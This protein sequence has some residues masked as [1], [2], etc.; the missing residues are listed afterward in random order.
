MLE[1]RQARYF[2]AV[3]EELHFG[4]AAER[5][6]MSQPPLSQ[7]IR[8]LEQQLGARLLDRNSRTVALTEPGRV[9]LGHCHTLVAAAERAQ[10]AAEQAQSGIIGMLTLGAVTAAFT[11]P[12]P[13][14]LGKFRAE[15]PRIQLRAR[16]LDTTEG[17][18]ALL[19]GHLDVA[20]IRYGGAGID[21]RLSSTPLRRDRLVAA[22]PAGHPL[23]AHDEIDLAE[24]AD[25]DWVWIPREHSPTYHDELVAACR[26]TGFSPMPVHQA[27]SIH[28]QL[29]MVGCGMGVGLVPHT[30]SRPEVPGVA[31]RPLC[32]P[33][34]LEGLAL[35]CR[36]E[37][38]GVLVEQFMACALASV[39]P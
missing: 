28:S 33:V 15:R 26:R 18:Q 31:Y 5:L 27:G 39:N 22:V 3:A 2:I 29:A 17:V 25:E 10:T 16:E 9:F 32:G 7:A 21:G 34:P 30:S 6:R 24:L 38:P 8:R 36:S 12:L 20:V 13:A 35:V 37:D 11:E 14:I 1:V 23:A 19:D 4:R